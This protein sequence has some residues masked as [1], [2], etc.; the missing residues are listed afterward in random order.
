MID[1]F[2]V[3]FARFLM[4]RLTRAGEK[5]QVDN[6]TV[7]QKVSKNLLPT[8]LQEGEVPPCKKSVKPQYNVES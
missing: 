4:N 5:K 7:L 8:E 1:W 2:P 3:Q 6:D